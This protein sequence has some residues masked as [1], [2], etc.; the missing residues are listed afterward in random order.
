MFG[1]KNSE[2]G[3]AMMQA[4]EVAGE[5]GHAEVGPDHLLL[6]LTANLRGTSQPLIAEHGLT[7]ADARNIVMTQHCAS[8]LD[9]TPRSRQGN[10]DVDDD[11]EA[12]ASI[13]IDLDKVTEAVASAFGHDITRAWGKRRERDGSG[14][15]NDTGGQ[16]FPPFG[17]PR[18][19]GRRG[20]RSRRFG[21]EPR[22]SE[23]TI[24]I[25]HELRTDARAARSAIHDDGDHRAARELFHTTF[26]P[27]RILLAILDT[28]DPAT[29]VLIDAMTDAEGLRATLRERLQAA[30]VA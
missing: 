21:R 18:G 4:H 3:I 8:N 27:E 16:W 2:V 5:L 25:L 14:E 7:Y 30:A 13:G 19:R 10:A 15:E 6:A 28:K 9:D 26:R 24:K 22:L 20:P 23:A 12:L 11:R 29:Q 1:F 17:G